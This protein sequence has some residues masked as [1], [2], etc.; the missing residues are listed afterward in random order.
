[1]RLF[2]LLICLCILSCSCAR[3]KEFNRPVDVH[4]TELEEIHFKR[5]KF[6]VST[7]EKITEVKNA[8]MNKKLETLSYKKN[9][10]ILSYNLEDLR[11]LQISNYNA[12][13]YGGVIGAIIGTAT[14]FIIAHQSGGRGCA[15]LL[16]LITTPSGLLCGHLIGSRIYINWQ[17]YDLGSY[18]QNTATGTHPHRNRYAG[19]TLKI[20]FR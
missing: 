15:D 19:L 5:A 8:V 11:S 14:P 13:K 17:E 10:E 16:S 1:M 3:I 2:I 9:K 7:D 20:P 12:G 4:N 6:S 18:K